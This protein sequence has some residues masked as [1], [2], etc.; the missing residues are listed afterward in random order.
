MELGFKCRTIWLQHMCS[1]HFIFSPTETICFHS[2]AFH[3]V[4]Q[5][6]CAGN[7]IQMPPCGNSHA[8]R[9][10]LQTLPLDT[11][12]IKM[13]ITASGWANSQILI[14]AIYFSLHFLSLLTLA[15]LQM[16][17]LCPAYSVR[18]SGCWIG[19][20][21]TVLWH[22]NQSLFIPCFLELLQNNSVSLLNMRKMNAQ[23]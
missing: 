11:S 16:S 7:I 8:P 13:Y 12:Y 20:T 9:P 2:S 10:H 17:W 14:D 21:P 22:H 3:L 23:P 19:L 18:W 6:L 4:L 5:S 1:L 15:L